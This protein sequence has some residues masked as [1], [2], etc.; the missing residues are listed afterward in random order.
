ME[1]KEKAIV[2]LILG[3]LKADPQCNATNM[4]QKLRLPKTEIMKHVNYLCKNGYLVF[5]NER[6]F[7]TESGLT[8]AVDPD[9]IPSYHTFEEKH[10]S[11]YFN[12]KDVEYIPSPEMFK[13]KK[14]NQLN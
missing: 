9:D 2:C 3:M 10:D 4:S 13:R 7:V 11:M 12:L 5:N 8:E 1:S 14:N 6:F